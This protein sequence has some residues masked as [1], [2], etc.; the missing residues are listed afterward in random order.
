MANKNRMGVLSGAQKH[1][2]Y[3]NWFDQGFRCSCETFSL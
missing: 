3:A 1:V 2:Q